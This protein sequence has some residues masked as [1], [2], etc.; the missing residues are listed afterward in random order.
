M[1]VDTVHNC[2]DNDS[3][4]FLP[5]LTAAD[6]ASGWTK[7]FALPNKAHKWASEAMQPLQSSLPF[8][9]VK[10][11]ACKLYGSS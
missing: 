8:P 5:A 3:A 7:L 4:E 10:R 11:H 9:R 6:A 1:Q 2:N